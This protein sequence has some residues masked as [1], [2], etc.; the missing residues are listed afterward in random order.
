MLRTEDVDIVCL[1]ETHISRGEEKYFFL[2]D[3]A[4]TPG[5]T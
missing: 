5:L 1:Q 3:M 4:H 2:L